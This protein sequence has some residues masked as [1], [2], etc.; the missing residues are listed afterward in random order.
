MLVEG[1]W[2]KSRTVRVLAHRRVSLARLLATSAIRKIWC[3]RRSQLTKGQL[4][5]QFGE[6]GV[7]TGGV[8]LVHA[9]F[10]RS[11]PVEG[12]PHGLVGALLAM[13]RSCSSALDTTPIA[14]RISACSTT[15]SKPKAASAE[16]ASATRKHASRARATSY[17]PRSSAC[18]GVK[19]YS[20]MPVGRAPNAMRR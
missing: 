17:R 20:R 4:I 5:Q 12:G 13:G 15:G 11:A 16:A 3:S 18:A 19:L 7:E 6:L 14:A 2:T 9:A 8:R 10:S 1:W